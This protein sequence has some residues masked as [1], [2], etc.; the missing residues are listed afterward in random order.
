MAKWIMIGA[1]VLFAGIGIVA[2]CKKRMG[3]GVERSLSSEEPLLSQTPVVFVS[4]SNIPASPPELTFAQPAKPLK[5]DFPEI[6]RIFQLF[7]TTTSS[8]LP[9]VE[10]ISY[11]SAVPWHKGRPAWIADYAIYYNTSRHFIAR[12]LNGKADYFTQT[13]AEKSKFNVF[14][15]AAKRV[16]SGVWHALDPS[17]CR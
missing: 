13:V 17:L 7:S 8:Q 14:R 6:D 9:I 12:S 4:K 11:S 1:L 16:D 5:G 3:T 2:F 10:T 15:K